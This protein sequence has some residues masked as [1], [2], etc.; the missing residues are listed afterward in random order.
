MAATVSSKLYLESC[1]SGPSSIG[2]MKET[3]N[4]SG[5]P[6]L[7]RAI[8]FLVYN[9]EDKANEIIRQLSETHPKITTELFYLTWLNAGSPTPQ[10]HP[11]LAHPNFGQVA[12][13]GEEGRFISKEDKGAILKD[14]LSKVNSRPKENCHNCTLNTS[15]AS[16]YA[17]E[18]YWNIFSQSDR[19]V[20]IIPKRH[21][22]S[23]DQLTEEETQELKTVTKKCTQVFECF[24]GNSAY[25]MT[26]QSQQSS[27]FH[28][29]VELIPS[30]SLP[31][32]LLDCTSTSPKF[33]EAY[34]QIKLIDKEINFLKAHLKSLT[35]K[36]DS[37]DTNWQK[38]GIK[39]RLEALI[40]EKTLTADQREEIKLL[41][42][43]L[44]E[45]YS[46]VTPPNFYNHLRIL[47]KA[48][49][50]TKLSYS[51]GRDRHD[52][53]APYFFNQVIVDQIGMNGSRIRFPKDETPYSEAP[54]Y[55]IAMSAPMP[56]FLP[57]TFE[58]YFRENIK[59]VINLTLFEE[60]DCIKA[61]RYL[62]MNA[63][64]TVVHKDYTI[65]SSAIDTTDLHDDWKV[66]T[67]RFAISN[68]EKS[69]EMVQFHVQGWKDFTD[70]NP[71]A[72]A[73]FIKILADEEKRLPSNGKIAIHCSGGV[74]RTGV[75]IGGKKVFEEIQQGLDPNVRSIT[76]MM[77]L[78]RPYLGGSEKQYA[79]IWKLKEIFQAEKH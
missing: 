71:Q 42:A 23:F 22:Q 14:M 58:M 57:E 77:R 26:M 48:F 16:V 12:F 8:E 72:I 63:N 70:G 40:Q 60:G 9:Q 28:F 24:F 53:C 49:E 47:D 51:R 36:S 35:S 13:F 79:M 21:I 18:K 50:N 43:I 4:A 54:T 2:I 78:Q 73:K 33:K 25:Q 55:C 29:V 5:K 65:H 67:N 6:Q 44:D 68:A 52:I 3:H 31:P 11:S 66:E 30:R 64:Q 37:D 38:L 75:L 56:E 1:A 39:W 32:S 10:T 61:D 34:E 41:L 7:E 74:G 59:I 27:D 69:H 62:P 20:L 15:K 45:K 17:S 76:A 19:S 46:T